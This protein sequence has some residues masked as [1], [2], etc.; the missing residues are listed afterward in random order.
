MGPL[1]KKLTELLAETLDYIFIDFPFAYQHSQIREFIDL[2]VFIDTP[3]DLALTRRMT[4]DFKTENAEEI[5]QNLQHYATKGRRAY[6]NMLETIKP[7]SDLVLDGSLTPIEIEKNII[8]HLK[9][10]Q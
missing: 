1:A 9:A 10:F 3:L 2:A 7:D 4:R 5:L 6:I 8:T